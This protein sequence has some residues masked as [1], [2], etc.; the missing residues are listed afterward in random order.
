M[1][2]Q[3]GVRGRRGPLFGRRLSFRTT[4]TTQSFSISGFTRDSDGTQLDACDVVLYESATDLPV[5]RTVSDAS[6]NYSMTL[7]NN[8]GTFYVVA[9]KDGS[10]DVFGTTVDTLVLS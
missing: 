7:G 1:G 9:Y 4:K 2:G 8:A 5:A 3:G 10:P 6:G